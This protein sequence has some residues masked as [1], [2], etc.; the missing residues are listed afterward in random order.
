MEEN[1]ILAK[2]LASR[3]LAKRKERVSRLGYRQPAWV[4]EDRLRDAIV[5]EHLLAFPSSVGAI[6]GVHNEE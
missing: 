3:G 2:H 6:N 5:L 4:N 1:E